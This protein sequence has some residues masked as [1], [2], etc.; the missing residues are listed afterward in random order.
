MS[1]KIFEELIESKELRLEDILSNLITKENLEL[2]TE[3]N[4]PIRISILDTLSES[5]KNLK[6]EKSHNILS[7]FLLWYRINMVS[8]KRLSRKEIIK[9]IIGLKEEQLEK[10]KSFFEKLLKK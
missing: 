8:H 3:I 6:F 5:L 7:S 2:K 4:N 1:E 10:E 9:G